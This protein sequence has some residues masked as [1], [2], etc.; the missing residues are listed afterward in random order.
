M[1]AKTEISVTD[2]E[3]KHIFV[4]NLPAVSIIQH[5]DTP[6]NDYFSELFDH[7]SAG[8]LYYARQFVSSPEDAED[9][10]HDAFVD[11][12]EKKE[13]IDYGTAMSYLFRV[14]RNDCLDYLK[15]LKTRTKYQ[16]RIIAE[17]NLPDAF[18]IDL[19]VYSELNERIEAA[20]AKLPPQQKAA[21]VKN[22]IDKKT[23]AE[24][25]KEMDISPRTVDKHI[26][27]A[28]KT[29]RIELADCLI[30][31]IYLGLL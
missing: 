10:V 29:L 28:V 22:R 19:Y 9:I 24:I 13:R 12:W 7:Y 21:F 3:K 31:V 2:N 27:L 17:N 5:Q 16:E 8:L 30:L 11:L 1:R 25:A 23:Y 18:D 26:Q 15:R 6:Y 20:I 14:T 4:S